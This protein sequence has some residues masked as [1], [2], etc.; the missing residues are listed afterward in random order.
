MK[1]TT[2][3]SAI[4]DAII[5]SVICTAL[6]GAIFLFFYRFPVLYIHL[7]AEDSWGEY[8]TITCFF[9]AFLM[10]AYAL[11]KR[12]ELRRAGFVL[13]GLFLLFCAME[14]MSWGQ[15]IFRIDSPE[16][17]KLYNNQKELNLHNLIFI[18]YTKLIFQYCV[19]L[20]VA[21][22]PVLHSR[23]ARFRKLSDF[24]GIP[25][26]P[27][28]LSPFFY[29]ALLFAFVHATPKSDEINE[30]FFS[31]GFL[32]YSV[33]LA[34]PVDGTRGDY[35]KRGLR[36]GAAL[37]LAFCLA[38]LF[39]WMWPWDEDLKERLNRFTT[40][41]YPRAGMYAQAEELFEYQMKNPHLLRNDTL[42]NYGFFLAQRGRCEERIRILY[43]ALEEKDRQIAE[44][45]HDPELYGIRGRI[46]EQLSQKSQARADF[47][48]Q[49]GEIER[50]LQENSAAMGRPGADRPLL[51]NDRIELLFSLGTAYIDLKD[52]HN[53]LQSLREA[54][55]LSRETVVTT[56]Q[57]N[58][59]SLFMHTAEYL[60]K[61]GRLPAT[62]VS[63]SRC[64]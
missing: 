47:Q 58:K 43:T 18:Q 52:Y 13:I 42:L 57:R 12:P 27:A 28:R 24:I 38:A 34:S 4:R 29:L 64:R 41:I 5:N 30:L 56:I 3:Q 17:F 16:T 39:A 19:L 8:A 35:P 54:E 50:L 33:D 55:R 9:I 11:V 60:K 62:S 36:T 25:I 45:P 48:K 63:R 61:Y 49:I 51:M 6:A 31:M 1:S 2:D 10:T 26:V 15:R 20:W 32:I 44:K 7:I 14:E 59:I 23:L 22:I 53:A 40:I 21:I 46:R 37:A